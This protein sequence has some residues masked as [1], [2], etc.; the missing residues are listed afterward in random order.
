MEHSGACSLAWARLTSETREIVQLNEAAGNG[1][2]YELEE[3]HDDV[4]DIGTTARIEAGGLGDSGL[5]GP[6]W[7]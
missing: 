1:I 7:P 4:C 6:V 3:H 5:V 2:E